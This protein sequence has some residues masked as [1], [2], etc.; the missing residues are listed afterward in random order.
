[1]GQEKIDP[2]SRSVKRIVPLD[3][4]IPLKKEDGTVEGQ[5][6]QVEIGRLTVGDL[7]ILPD[8]FLKKGVELTAY[9]MRLVVLALTHLP[10]ATC[11]MIDLKDSYKIISEAES[12]LM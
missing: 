12:L 10:E 8:N 5:I 3:Y 6:Y 9:E 11:D 4:P 7:K 1:M 2:A